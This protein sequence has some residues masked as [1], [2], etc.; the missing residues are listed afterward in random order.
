[1]KVYFPIL[2]FFSK[3]FDRKIYHDVIG[4]NLDKYVKANSKFRC[5]LNSFRINWVETQSM[6]NKLQECGIN[7]CEVLPNFKRLN[8]IEAGDD[9]YTKP[10][11]FCMFSRVMKEKGVEDAIEAIETINKELTEEVCKLDIFGSIDIGYKKR[12]KEIIKNTTG[13]INYKGVIAYDKSVE[14]I[15]DY[16]ALLFPTFWDGEGFPGTIVDA[17]SAALPVVATDWNC[18]AEIIVNKKNGIL[19]PNKEIKNLKEAI[20]WMIDNSD[21][22]NDLKA[23]CSMSAKYYQP[24]NHIDRIINT[25]M[26][27]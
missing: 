5:Y 15:K 8:V 10:Y 22:M 27:G 20:Y 21:K 1:M 23:N 7:N 9:N 24:K 16:Y 26:E 3:V 19:Y 13:A 17:F 11:R 25:I 2:F 18:N 6:K 14:A 12:F 4:G